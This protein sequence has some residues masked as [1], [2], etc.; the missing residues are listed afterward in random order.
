MDAI[1]FDTHEFVRTLRQ[2]G[3][4]EKQAIAYKDALKGAAF[5]TRHDLE[6]MENR[7]IAKIAGMQ[8][9]LV[10]A[11]AALIKIL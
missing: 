5:A 1:P 3:V 6:M 10:I 7:I 11:I 9:L 2:A 4:D 8:V